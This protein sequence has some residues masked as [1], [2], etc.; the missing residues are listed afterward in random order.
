M[1]LPAHICTRLA[2]SSCR[3]I[4]PHEFCISLLLPDHAT[5]LFEYGASA[6]ASFFKYRFF[7]AVNDAV[8]YRFIRVFEVVVAAARSQNSLEEIIRD[9]YHDPRS[10]Y[11]VFAA[12]SAPALS[13]LLDAGLGSASFTVPRSDLVCWAA[14]RNALACLRLLHE[15]CSPLARTGLMAA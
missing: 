15:R 10:L 8:A 2:T 13:I 11:R 1:S 5:V 9:E 3:A 14:E 4:C 7:I 12:D 6:A